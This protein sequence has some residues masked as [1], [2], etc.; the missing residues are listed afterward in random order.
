M[1]TAVSPEAIQTLPNEPE[2]LPSLAELLEDVGKELDRDREAAKS[3][4]RRATSLI[5]IHIERHALGEEASKRSGLAGWQT[6][7][8]RLYI[9]TRL[10]QPILIEELS[11]IA[12]LS[13]AHFSRAFK[14]AFN[15]TPH[16][17]IVRR[18]L[19]K[20]ESMMLTSDVP[21]MNIATDCGLSHQA[22]LC[23]LFRQKHGV[24]PAAWRRQRT[25]TDRP[26]NR[27]AVPPHPAS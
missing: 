8:L 25:E 26:G 27:S 20:A 13:K 1:Q 17:Y 21:L 14:Q 23:K 4:L 3:L 16:S 22:H 24:T 6:R 9:E 2:L 7:R 18:R 5:R 10:D 15:T 12:N 11:S 19:E